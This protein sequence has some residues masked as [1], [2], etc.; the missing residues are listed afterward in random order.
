MLIV[1][2]LAWRW[3]F[4]ALAADHQSKFY[5]ELAKQ[6]PGQMAFFAG[7]AW[8]YYRS[9]AGGG[10]PV[11]LAV[12]GLAAYVCVEGPFGE[13]LHPLDVTL[14]VYWAAM[15]CPRLP[16]L[17]RYGDFS[18]GTYLCHF[19]LIQLAIW[20]GL[21]QLSTTLAVFAVMVALA[22]CAACSWYCVER[23]MLFSR[24]KAA[25]SS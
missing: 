11:L 24:A 18:Y 25:I 21:F 2:S 3:G 22:A 23:P 6:L 15:E 1:A 13:F 8:T 4:E 17:A 14:I 12:C 19:P 16:S 5:G 7:G 20:L 10:I 9:R